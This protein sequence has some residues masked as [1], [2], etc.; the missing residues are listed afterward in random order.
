MN[1]YS[2]DIS[3]WI[4]DTAGKLSM[5]EEGAYIRMANHYFRSEEPL[6]IELSKLFRMVQAH[7]DQERDAVKA[8]LAEFFIQTDTG[9]ISDKMDEK[10]EAIYAKSEKARKSIAV[11]WAKREARKHMENTNV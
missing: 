2:I 10:K 11:R 4:A 1:F 7:T 9:F 8:I 6:P 5:V 3:D